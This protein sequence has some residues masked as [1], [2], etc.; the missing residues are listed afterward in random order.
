MKKAKERLL[1]EVQP[2]YSKELHRGG[3][4]Q[5]HEMAIKNSSSHEVKLAGA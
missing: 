5:Y 3:R 2:S 1:V 4:C